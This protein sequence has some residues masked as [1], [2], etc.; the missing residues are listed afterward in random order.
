MSEWTISG[1]AC[2][3]VISS[4][5][6]AWRRLLV[7]QS[8]IRGDRRAGS[9]PT[10]PAG[11]VSSQGYAQHWEALPLGNATSILCSAEAAVDAPLSLPW[12]AESPCNATTSTVASGNAVRRVTRLVAGILGHPTGEAGARQ[13]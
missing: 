8:N 2:A 3:A 10:P 9:L 5:G 6:V 1:R 4:P 12:H 13:Q 11:V 7:E